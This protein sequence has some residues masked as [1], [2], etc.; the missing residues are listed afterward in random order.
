MIEV[1]VIL[2][3]VLGGGGGTPLNIFKIGR[4]NQCLLLTC[5]VLGTKTGAVNTIVTVA[6]PTLLI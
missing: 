6:C 3:C 4:P 5:G 2:V 1:Q